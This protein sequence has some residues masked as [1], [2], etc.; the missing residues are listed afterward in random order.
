MT[1]S[2]RKRR[3]EALVASWLFCGWVGAAGAQSD[4]KKDWER[5]QE[6]AKKEA[7][8]VVGIPAR[9]ELRKELEKVFKPKFGIDMDLNSARGPQNASRIAAEFA[10]GTKYFDVFIGGSGTY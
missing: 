2:T 9:A 4:W 6:E 10:A 7:L 5:L 3:L 8:V 1:V